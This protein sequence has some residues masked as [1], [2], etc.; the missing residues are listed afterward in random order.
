V[1]IDADDPTAKAAVEAVRSG[2]VEGLRRLLADHP[3]LVTAE[4]AGDCDT[5]RSLLHVLTDWPGHFPNGPAVVRL[6]VTAG[7]EVNV[8]FTGSHR[9]TPLHWAA[10]SDDVEVLDALLDAGADIEAVGGV[11]ADGTP[12]TDASVF[13][14]WRAA[15]RLL[16][17]GAVPS[18]WEAATMGLLDRVTAAWDSAEPPSTQ[19]V[20]EAFWGACHG[21]Q[22]V[23]AEFLLDRGADVNWIGWGDQTPLDAAEADGFTELAAWLRGIGARSNR[24]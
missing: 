2:D 7:A 10:S 11:I 17:R 4:I 16:E 15:R 21:G 1:I 19:A 14:Q 23:T 8:R 22:R 3:E 9:E 13:G 24:S 18:F 5:A 20:T 6:L 12:L